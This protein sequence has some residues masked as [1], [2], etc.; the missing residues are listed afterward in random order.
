MKKLHDTLLLSDYPMAWAVAGPWFARCR[1]YS[2]IDT[3]DANRLR[4]TQSEI[5]TA[6][7]SSL[8]AR[9]HNTGARRGF[10][11]MNRA[12]KLRVEQRQPA[13]GTAARM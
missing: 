8:A 12:L 1:A 11:E 3:L 5:F 6:L 13:D 7:C 9:L 2:I 4:F 10:R